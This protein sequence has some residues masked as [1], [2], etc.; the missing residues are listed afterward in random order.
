MGSIRMNSFALEMWRLLRPYRLRMAL[1]LLFGVVYSVANSLLLVTVKLLCDLS[2]PAAGHVPLEKELQRLPEGLQRWLHEVLPSLDRWKV[3]IILMVP[4][5]MLVRGV[6]NYLNFYLVNWATIRAVMD[7]RLR[8]FRHLQTLSVGFFNA[9]R[10]GEL[11]SRISNDPFA[12]SVVLSQALPIA[13]KDPITVLGAVAFLLY[14]QTELTVISLVIFPICIVPIAV[15]GKKVRRA[16]RLFQEQIAESNTVVQE[17]FTNARVVKAYRLESFL[18]D[19]FKLSSQRTA[20]QM[21]RMIRAGEIPGPL[22]EFVGALGM[23]MMFLYVN[24]RHFALTSGDFVSFVL[25]IFMLYQPLKMVSKLPSLW[26][27]AKAATERIFELLAQQSEVREPAVPVPLRA[28]GAEIHL[29]HVSFGYGEALALNDV[30][31]KIAP[32]QVVAL[33]GKSGSGKTTIIN[34]LL[35]FYDPQQGAVRIGGVDLRQVHTSTLRDQMAVVTQETILFNETIRTNILLGRPDATEAEVTAA[36][37]AAHALDFILEKPGGFDFVVGERGGN[38]SGGQR[39][40]ISI[41]RAILRNAPIL[42]LDEATSAL[43]TESER[44]VQAAFD[45]LMKGRT[46]VCIAHRLSTIQHADR[47]VVMNEG[48]IVEMGTHPELLA[49]DGAYRRLYELQFGGGKESVGVPGI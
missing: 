23:A 18:V 4:L 36:A 31:L 45:E 5:V 7:L 25:S 42:L 47:I 39:Q 11:M 41:A 33:V 29:D 43:D 24:H 44:E 10:T 28:A 32:G 27:Q 40:R 48:R 1:G 34:L 26:Q 15:Y 3:F 9:S 21:L 16:S 20:S 14:Q 38:L 6:A 49:R 8:I 22:L 46:T 2:F 35:R 12:T 30:E 13:A 19:R 37:R 17:A